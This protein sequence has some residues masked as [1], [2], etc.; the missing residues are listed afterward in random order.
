MQSNQ[1]SLLRQGDCKTR[2]A[3]KSCISEQK[4]TQNPYKQWEIHK[5]INQQLQNHR[6]RTDSSLSHRGGGGGLNAFY[7]RQIFA[8]DSVV[9]NTQRLFSSREGFLTNAMHHHRE[10]NLIKLTHLDKR[11]S[12]MTNRLS[13]QE[14]TPS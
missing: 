2:K 4:P 13:E 3:I 10:K 1:L 14:Q 5:T 9:V 7:W 6:F 12:L 8:L 11:K